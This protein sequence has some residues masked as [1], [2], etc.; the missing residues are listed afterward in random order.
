MHTLTKEEQAISDRH[1]TAHK[2]ACDKIRP[3]L[4]PEFL[5]T[6]RQSAKIVGWDYDYIEIRAF[7]SECYRMAQTEPKGDFE[8]YDFAEE[9]TNDLTTGFLRLA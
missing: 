3:F 5:E 4:T 9:V 1:D 6:L 8:P 2:D 7:V